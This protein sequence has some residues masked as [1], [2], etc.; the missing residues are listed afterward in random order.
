LIWDY[1]LK[2]NMAGFLAWYED[3]PIKS[4]EDLIKFN[5][6]HADVELPEGKSSPSPPPRARLIFQRMA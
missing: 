4:L 3:P 1:D 5:S 2:A 6:E